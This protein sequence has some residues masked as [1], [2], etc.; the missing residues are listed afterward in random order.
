MSRSTLGVF[1]EALKAQHQPENSRPKWRSLHHRGVSTLQ[2]FSLSRSLSSPLLSGPRCVCPVDQHQLIVCM[3]RS[4]PLRVAVSVTCC[5]AVPV[6]EEHDI[7]MPCTCG[8]SHESYRHVGGRSFAI[9]STRRTLQERAWCKQ[10]GDN[11]KVLQLE[12]CRTVE[13]SPAFAR[14]SVI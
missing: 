2:L 13:K 10:S 12:L 14:F 11:T 6:S 7:I 8:R 3:Q 4:F 5:C 9:N 1:C